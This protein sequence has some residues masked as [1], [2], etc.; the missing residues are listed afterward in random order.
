MK[1]HAQA[2]AHFR[3]ALAPGAVAAYA[4]WRCPLGQVSLKPGDRLQGEFVV[5]MGKL[6]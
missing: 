4:L 1:L 6:P 3:A 5:E 2:D